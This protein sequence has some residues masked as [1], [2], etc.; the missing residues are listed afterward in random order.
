MIC[1]FVFLSFIKNVTSY[2]EESLIEKA[3]HFLTPEVLFGS[4][5]PDVLSEDFRF[6]FPVV[7]PLSK[8]EFCKAFGSF[9]TDKAFPLDDGDSSSNYFGFTI[10]PIEPNRVWFF[11]R[12]KFVHKGKLFCLYQI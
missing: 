12:A 5:N 10:D 2:S 3:Q 11:S 9:Q 8:A 1:F 4:K 7:G 6:I